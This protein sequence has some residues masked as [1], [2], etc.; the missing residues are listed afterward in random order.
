MNSPSSPDHKHHKQDCKIFKDQPKWC[1]LCDE[2][3]ITVVDTKPP[4]TTLYDS[5]LQPLIH[6]YTPLQLEIDLLDNQVIGLQDFLKPDMDPRNVQDPI[7]LINDM[8]QKLVDYHD[9]HKYHIDWTPFYIMATTPC[10]CVL[11]AI[12]SNNQTVL[13]ASNM[14][15][16]IWLA[17]HWFFG[18]I[19]VSDT[20]MV[21]QRNQ[22]TPL[23][24]P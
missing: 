13:T 22:A 23:K 19:T 15:H 18:A 11:G 5:K 4:Q 3:K 20:K 6:N 24:P 10:E 12:T 16:C 7:K 17:T 8:T 14:L 2:G 9:I 21:Y 1:N